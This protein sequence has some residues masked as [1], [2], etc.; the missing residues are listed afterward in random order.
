VAGTTEAPADL[1]QSASALGLTTAIQRALRD[2]SGVE[3]G[4]WQLGEG[5]GWKSQ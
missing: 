4:I 3:G 2:L 5:G 1:R